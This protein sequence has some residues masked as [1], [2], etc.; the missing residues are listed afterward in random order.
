MLTFSWNME[1]AKAHYKAMYEIE[2]I[3]LKGETLK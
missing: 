1:I 2:K 3:Y